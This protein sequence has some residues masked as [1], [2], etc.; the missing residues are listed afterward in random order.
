MLQRAFP[1]LCICLLDL[2]AFTLAVVL[3]EVPA[4]RRPDAVDNLQDA[5]RLWALRALS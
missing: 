4:L 2:W 1:R 5:L 3:V